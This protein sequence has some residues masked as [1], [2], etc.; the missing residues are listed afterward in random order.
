MLVSPCALLKSL[1]TVLREKYDER[2]KIFAH[3]Y[4][5]T[6]LLKAE[7]EII[8]VQKIITRHR[9]RCPHCKLNGT[10]LV[11]ADARS[12]PLPSERSGVPTRIY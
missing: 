2:N 1:S 8:R 5:D 7:L 11:S 12:R 10:H 6:S 3:G 9:R 4:A